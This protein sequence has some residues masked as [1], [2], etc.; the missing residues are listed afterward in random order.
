M[1]ARGQQRHYLL[2]GRERRRTGQWQP[3]V[4]VVGWCPLKGPDDNGYPTDHGRIYAKGEKVD[5]RSD[6]LGTGACLK[7]R[8]RQLKTDALK[9]VMDLRGETLELI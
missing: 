4:E 6:L 9:K 3:I 8:T 2:R 1:A 5:G 7:C